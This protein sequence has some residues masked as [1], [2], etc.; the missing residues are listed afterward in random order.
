MSGTPSGVGKFEVN[1]IFEGKI[2]YKDEVL[3]NV[4]F[5]VK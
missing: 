3:L 2:L 4:K 1:D 5:E